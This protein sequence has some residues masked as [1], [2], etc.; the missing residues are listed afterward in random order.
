MIATWI[1]GPFDGLSERCD[2]S[3]REFA[4]AYD[5]DERRV[6]GVSDLQEVAINPSYRC[7]DPQIEQVKVIRMFPVMTINSQRHI[8]YREPVY[9]TEVDRDK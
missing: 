1:G 6:Y 5:A 2:E 8:Q 3:A 9:A 4:V 7:V